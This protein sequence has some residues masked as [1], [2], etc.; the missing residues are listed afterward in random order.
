MVDNRDEQLRERAYGIWQAEGEP[1][2]RDREH[3][4]MA[5]RELAG[6]DPAPAA[7]EPVQT[8]D[9]PQAAEPA[10]QPK[11]AVTR[12]KSSKLTSPAGTEASAPAPKPKAR[13]PR[14]AKT[15]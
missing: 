5:E 6:A 7:P 14:A 8:E 10:P 12:R 2:G 1:H 11:A 13:K 15:E 4:E 3:W 9:K